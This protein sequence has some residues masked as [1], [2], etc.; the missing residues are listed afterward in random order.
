MQWQTSE[1]RHS[2]QRFCDAVLAGDTVVEPYTRNYLGGHALALENTYPAVQ[3]LLGNATFAAL[4]RVCAVHYPAVQWDL[5]LYGETFAVLLAAQAQGVKAADFDWCLLADLA[6]IEY[7][8]TQV[9]Y[10]DELDGE[11]CTP[12]LI[13]TK[14]IAENTCCVGELQ[15][16]HPGAA[17]AENLS[18]NRPVAVWREGV[19]VVVTN[20][21]E[22]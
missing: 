16:G 21:T 9:Y 7:A 18:L 2:L 1:Y 17:I 10:A 8:I 13:A 6:R 11:P 12:L 4:A 15:R 3:C 20:M 22:L 14:S 19:R 5:N